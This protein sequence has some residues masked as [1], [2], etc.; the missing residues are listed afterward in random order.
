[1][2]I[3]DKHKIQIQCISGDILFLQTTTLPRSGILTDFYCKSLIENSNNYI[4][5]ENKLLINSYYALMISIISMRELAGWDAEASVSV[6]W[7]VSCT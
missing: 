5:K 2:S 6:T 3:Q 7:K 1:M 4:K